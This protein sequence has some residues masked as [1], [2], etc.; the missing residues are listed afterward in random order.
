MLVKRIYAAVDAD[1][2]IVRTQ[3]RMEDEDAGPLMPPGAD[4]SYYVCDPIDWSARPTPSYKLKWRGFGVAPEW[5]RVWTLD[6]IRAAKQLQMS[7][8]CAAHIVGG[9]LSSALGAPHLYPAKPT[10]QANLV[11]SVTDS[12]LVGGDAGWSTPFPCADAYGLWLFREHTVAQIQQ[13]GRDGKAAILAATGKNEALR[14]QIE[15]ADADQI[16]VIT[17]E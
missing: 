15:V 5:V 7:E 13:V 12:L 8:A 4:L 2:S 10:D 14:Q 6:E 11:A 3:S 9:F 16:E 17:W 1:G